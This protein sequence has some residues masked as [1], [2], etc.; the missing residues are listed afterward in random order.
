MGERDSIFQVDWSWVRFSLAFL[1]GRRVTESHGGYDPAEA[2]DPKSSGPNPN[3]QKN[4]G[5]QEKYLG[6]KNTRGGELP[7]YRDHTF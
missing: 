4:W 2:D 1:C 7:G 6:T 5:R 3:H